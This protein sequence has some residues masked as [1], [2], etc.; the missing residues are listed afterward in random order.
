MIPCVQRSTQLT[1]HPPS[2]SDTQIFFTTFLL[3]CVLVYTSPPSP[4]FTLFCTQPGL[5]FISAKPLN[6][7][8]PSFGLDSWMHLCIEYTCACISH[9]HVRV[10]H[11]RARNIMRMGVPRARH[12]A[13]DGQAWRTFQVG[14]PSLTEVIDLCLTNK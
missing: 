5:V 10:G 7:L 8:P 12:P 11:P 14:S 3:S 1:H 2:L 9:A 6:E 13:G 4:P